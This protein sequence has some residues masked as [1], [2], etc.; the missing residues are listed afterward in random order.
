[1]N[2]AG[3]TLLEVVVVILIITILATVVGIN[4]AKEPDR[5]GVAKATA[6]ISSFNTALK[7]YHMDNGIYPAM[8]QGLQALCR[9]PDIPPVPR[10]YRAH[11]Y[12]D[13]PEVPLDP[14]GNEYVYLLPGPNDTE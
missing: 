11:G 3:F 9:R 8:Q 10:H 1:M 12:L 2:R 13:K 6:E 14:W 4:V 7:L 5:A